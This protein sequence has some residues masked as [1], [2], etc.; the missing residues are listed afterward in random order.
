MIASAVFTRLAHKSAA[1]SIDIA[2]NLCVGLIWPG[3]PFH[4]KL[5]V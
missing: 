4:A 5:K 1:M 2:G 3:V